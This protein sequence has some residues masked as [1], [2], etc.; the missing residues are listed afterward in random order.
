[1]V[2]A[3][4]QRPKA[5]PTEAELSREQ[6]SQ[7]A[8]LVSPQ[9]R[10]ICGIETEFVGCSRKELDDLGLAFSRVETTKGPELKCEKNGQYVKS[11]PA[12][13]IARI[14]VTKLD[15]ATTVEIIEKPLENGVIQCDR[16][17]S[18]SAGHSNPTLRGR[19]RMEGNATYDGSTVVGSIPVELKGY[20][21]DSLAQI[22]T[23]IVADAGNR[24]QI[25]CKGQTFDL[26]EHT[27]AVHICP[28]YP[29]INVAAV[30]KAGPDGSAEVCALI[31][32]A[33]TGS[34]KSQSPAPASECRIVDNTAVVSTAGCTLDSLQEAHGFRIGLEPDGKLMVHCNNCDA[35]QIPYPPPGALI[36]VQIEGGR[37]SMHFPVRE[38]GSGNFIHVSY[39]FD[40]KNGSVSR[41]ESKE[42]D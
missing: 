16:L 24:L 20:T 22:N 33:Q 37:V 27:V 26:P 28:K 6:D 13:Q 8:R 36:F 3:A 31:L 21:Q 25:K 42:E 34:I 15:Q 41:K 40:S 32:D 35:T 19:F 14:K 18:F 23:S 39:L 29:G 4:L 5:A 38:E 2:T 9:A 30:Q 17:T 1:M 11:T 12:D 10:G 7:Q